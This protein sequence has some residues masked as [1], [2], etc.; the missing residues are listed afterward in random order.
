MMRSKADKTDVM[1]MRKMVLDDNMFE[2]GDT[3]YT[4]ALPLSLD[5]I[6][7]APHEKMG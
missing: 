3:N 5:W 1:E 7:H 6:L 2:F 4:K